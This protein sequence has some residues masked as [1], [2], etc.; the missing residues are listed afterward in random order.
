MT[1]DRE[2][3]IKQLE[4]CIEQ[5]I[6]PLKHIP[7]NL[8][9]KSMSGYEVEF[10]DFQNQVHQEVLQ[11][12][13]KTG[14]NLTNKTYPFNGRVNEFGNHIER[15]VK[16]ELN[17]LNIK[18][19]TPTNSQ[20]KKVS[21]GYPDIEFE[22]KNKKY[23]LECKTF[24][25]KNIN[26]SFR[27]FY[28]SPEKNS[29]ITTSTIHFLISFEKEKVENGYLIKSFKIISL[30]SMSCNLKSEFNASNKEMYSN[31]CGAEILFDSNNL[32]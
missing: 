13:I 24:D 16:T 1:N 7:F 30:N 20:G 25:K 11:L 4:S 18:A 3:Y 8:I 27:S 6:K 31:N 19:D 28:F 12:L 10:F 2:T 17:K 9:I 14:N 29:K 23:Y 21:S 26:D 5:A 15:I 22:Y 32:N